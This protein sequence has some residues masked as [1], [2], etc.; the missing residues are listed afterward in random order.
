MIGCILYGLSTWIFVGLLVSAT[1]SGFLF[2]AHKSNQT[3]G[4]SFGEKFYWEP[5]ERGQRLQKQAQRRICFA[6]IPF[7]VAAFIELFGLPLGLLAPETVCP[8]WV[9]TPRALRMLN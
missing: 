5:D 4:M 6:M 2:N 7:G 9:Q 3:T 1:V 8:G